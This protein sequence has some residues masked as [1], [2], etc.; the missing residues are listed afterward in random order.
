MPRGRTTEPSGGKLG[1]LSAAT[2]SVMGSARSA[3]A[4]VTKS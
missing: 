2:G 4:I 3:A 1:L